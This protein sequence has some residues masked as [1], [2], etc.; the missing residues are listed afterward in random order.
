MTGWRL[1]YIGAPK[2]I[3]DACVKI[4]G[5]FTSGTCSITQ[6]AVITAMEMDPKELQPMKDAFQKRRDLIVKLFREIPHVQVNHPEGAFY[7]FPKIDWY[8]GKSYGKTT[9]RDAKELCLWLLDEAHVALT[10]GGSFGAPEY[11]RLSYA[12]SE[13]KIAEAC[14]RIKTAL[15]KLH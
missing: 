9:I 1:G 10:P 6:R 15:A 4:Q 13:E 12:T 2:A 8:F 14:K 7:L 11:F 3:A 5:Q